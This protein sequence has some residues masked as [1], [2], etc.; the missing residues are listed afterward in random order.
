[1]LTFLSAVTLL[2][3]RCCFTFCC[4]FGGGWGILGGSL[5]SLIVV[6][7]GAVLFDFFCGC[8][9]LGGVWGVVSCLSVVWGGSFV[10]FLLAGGGGRQTLSGGARTIRLRLTESTEW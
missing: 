3:G 9:V 2:F 4:C 5:V 7:F 6:V 8:C 1:M 10:D